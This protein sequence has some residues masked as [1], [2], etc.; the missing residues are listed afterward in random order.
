MGVHGAQQRRKGL[1]RLQGGRVQQAINEYTA[2]RGR[3]KSM[4]RHAM[5][6]GGA[7]AWPRMHALAGAGAKL[8][9]S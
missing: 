8:A 2:P 4:R 1:T 7:R 6:V 9:G 5:I 3:G